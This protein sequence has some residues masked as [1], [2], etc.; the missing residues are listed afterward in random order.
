[1]SL[2]DLIEEVRRLPL[3]EKVELR[4]AIDME[5]LEE[6]PSDRDMET[7]L[8]EPFF[9]SNFEGKKVLKHPQWS[10][11]GVG[12]TLAEAHAALLQEAEDVA[13]FYIAKPDD[14]LTKEG[15]AFKRFLAKLVL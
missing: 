12:E 4:Q 10:L 7:I 3:D 2:L 11:M 15:V 9:L 8:G 6:S 13:E 14:G 5:L 1:M